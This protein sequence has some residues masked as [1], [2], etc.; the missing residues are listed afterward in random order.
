[1]RR[2]SA[3][4]A[5]LAAALAV[6]PAA[7]PAQYFG[8]NK[9]QYGNFD[10]KVIQTEHFDIHYYDRAR[11]AALDVGRM[12]ERAY[13]R[14]AS[15][16]DH[17]F[18]E[19]KVIIVYASPSDFAQTNTTPGD[20][21]E[22]TG[23]FTDFFKQRNI[24]PLTGAYED[25]EHVLVHEMVHQFQMDIFSSGRTVGSVQQIAQVAPPLWF[26]EGMA[27]Y[28]STGPVTPETAMW[29]RDAVLRDRLPTI[30]QM[31]YDPR[32]FPYRFGHSLWAYIAE[33]WGDEA[34]GA[35]LKGVPLVG[36]ELAIRRSLGLP[37]PQLTQQ[38][39]DHVRAQY[40]PAIANEV[41][42]KTIA[43]PTITTARSTGT[44]H[45]GPALSP[46]GRSMVFLS[47]ADF[48]FVDMWQADVATGRLTNRVLKS[49]WNS[50]FHTFRFINS[51][52]NFSPDGRF[53]AFAA[54][55]GKYD[56]LILVDVKRNRQVKRIRV[57]LDGVTTPSWSP[58]GQRLVFTGYDGGLTDLF[59]VNRDGSGLTRLT[60]DK[61]ADLHPMWSPDGTTI[62]FTTDRGPRTN[63]EDMVFGN[64]RLALYDV[65]SKRISLL[66]RMDEGRNVNPVWAPDGKSLAFVSD[67]NGVANLFLYDLAQN[68]V[69]Q[70][71]SLFSGIQ[72]ITP[73]S[74]VLSW[75]READKLA[76]VAFEGGS[77]FDIYTIDDPRR[78]RREPWRGA[79]DS[80][81]A[82]GGAVAA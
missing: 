1:M 16:L 63:F 30:E 75:A 66:D 7:L 65:G 18:R 78:L 54:K 82:R 60:N 19:R 4:A 17:R 55:T 31:T 28:L 73:L 68:E 70:L 34:I 6:F 35:I 44:L 2:P 71:T 49:T 69:Y 25:I 46:D 27:E 22:G 3:V 33:R 50:D 45:L 67:R 81:R 59:V 51:Q 61:Y 77:R 62:A 47:E 72:G 26:M 36:F 38:W 41:T 43:T 13:A 53:L 37:I 52:A 56:D 24:F 11:V 32:I 15:V 76:F 64:Y 9:V 12:A 5:A 20:V 42:A 74:P 39:H 21:G 29:M 80:A 48:F 40:Y 10:F 58:D 79:A 14:L 8:Q 23:G 57:K